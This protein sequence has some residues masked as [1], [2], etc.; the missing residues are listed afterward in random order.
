ME[1]TEDQS[2]TWKI[3]IPESEKGNI[4]VKKILAHASGT[5]EKI[6]TILA[7]S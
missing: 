5:I 2:I 1:G 7:K 6:N 4:N 3:L